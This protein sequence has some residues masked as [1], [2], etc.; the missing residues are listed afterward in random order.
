MIRPTW[1]IN[2]YV[3]KNY[4]DQ[5]PDLIMKNMTHETLNCGGAVVIPNE[6]FKN[7]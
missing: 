1:A 6:I 2:Q 7:S 4:Q 3:I 5:L